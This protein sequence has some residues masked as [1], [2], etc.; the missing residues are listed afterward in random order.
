MPQGDSFLAEKSILI[1]GAT[2]SFGQTMVK[3]LLLSPA[4][5]III[6]SRDELKQWQM[7]QNPAFQSDKLRFF[8]G[9]IRDLERLK[10][11]LKS[12]DIVIHAAALK[13]VPA[14]EYN[15]SEFIKT[16]VQGTMNLI[17]AAVSAEVSKVLFLSTDKAV[18]PINLYGATKMCAEK[19]ILSAGVYS[20]KTS[21]SVMRYGNVMSSRG[22]VIQLWQDLVQKGVTRLPLTHPE[23]TRFWLTL[24]QA[25][26]HVMSA[27][28]TMQGSE[29][30]VPNIPSMKLIDLAKIISGSS[31]VQVTGIRPGE[32]LH[33]TL[34]SDQDSATVFQTPEHFVLVPQF[35][36]QDYA[37]RAR[38]YWQIH[39]KKMDPG[40]AF[41]SNENC[42]YL[43][44]DQMRELMTLD[45]ESTQ[46]IQ[47]TC[48]QTKETMSSQ[49][50]ST[51]F[52]REREKVIDHNTLHAS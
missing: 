17:E 15:P 25:C 50:H 19:L 23:M 13:Q 33:E 51:L 40:F 2:G 10:V 46:T 36:G 28:Q 37:Y 49:P 35:T 45:P 22:S 11:A 9:D 31:E 3:Q 26:G 29:I 48:K 44:E 43:T 20:D 32:K 5:R 34:I 18:N 30:F 24:Q 4:R 21:F 12:V 38:N 8:L 7:Q 52:K 27:L 1:T 39:A 42:S 14:A 47:D 16:N 41:S 6:F